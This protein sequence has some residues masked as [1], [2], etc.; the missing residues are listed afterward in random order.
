MSEPIVVTGVVESDGVK[1]EESKAR[2]TMRACAVGPGVYDVRV[3]FRRRP[4]P[5]VKV[6]WPDWLPDIARVWVSSYS[7]GFRSVSILR[8]EAWMV[9]S[10][11]DPGTFGIW[12]ANESRIARNVDGYVVLEKCE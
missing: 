8:R 9:V 4:D 5:P 11:C 12:P 2:D 10:S 6:K 3:E 7:D 1:W